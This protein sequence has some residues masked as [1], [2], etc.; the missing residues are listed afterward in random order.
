MLPAVKNILPEG[1]YR[2]WDVIDAWAKELAD[3][4]AGKVVVG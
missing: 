3:E 1:D 4:I 2:Q